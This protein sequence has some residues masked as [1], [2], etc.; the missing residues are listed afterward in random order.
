[1]ISVLVSESKGGSHL[2]HQNIKI[3]RIIDNVWIHMPFR[4]LQEDRSRART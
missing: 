3:A 1:M 4:A 2:H